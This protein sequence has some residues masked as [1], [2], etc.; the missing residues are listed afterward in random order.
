MKKMKHSPST[1]GID[2]AKDK[3]DIAVHGSKELLEVANHDA[4]H[5]QLV[6]WLGERKIKRVGIEARG[7]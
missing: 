3:L 4:G 6:D 5:E 7:G 2:T 1:A